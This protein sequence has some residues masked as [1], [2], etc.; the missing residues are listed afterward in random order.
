MSNYCVFCQHR[1]NEHCNADKEGLCDLLC[2]HYNAHCLYADRT[3]NNYSL[4]HNLL[5]SDS[6]TKPLGI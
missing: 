5:N 4:L 1:D 2:Q 6:G 3:H